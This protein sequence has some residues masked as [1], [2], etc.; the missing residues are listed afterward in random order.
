MWKG[1]SSRFWT[2]G[3][4]GRTARSR[5]TVVRGAAAGDWLPITEAVSSLE[6]AELSVCGEVM[7][8]SG[9]YGMHR[10][11]VGAEMA[12]ERFEEF[13]LT[14]GFMRLL[15]I[16][17]EDDLLVATSEETVSAVVVVWNGG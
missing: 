8:W 11:E 1:H 6:D 14:S 7:M 2:F 10:L 12:A 15:S 16:F 13:A 3:A 9:G 4:D 17:L 5:G